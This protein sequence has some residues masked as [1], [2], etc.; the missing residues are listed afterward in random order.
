MYSGHRQFCVGTLNFMLVFVFEI[1]MFVVICSNYN[2]SLP[3]LPRI[4]KRPW[5][6][7][8]FLD[9]IMHNMV[10]SRGSPAQIIQNSPDVR[11][12]FRLILAEGT[13]NSVKPRERNLR[14]AKHRFESYQRPLGRTVRLFP[15]IV[16]LM[17]Q[18][19]HT[20]RDRRCQNWLE[21]VS[22]SPRHTMQLAMLADAA[23]EGMALTRFCDKEGMDVAALS[24]R[25]ACFLDRIVNLFGPNR[26]CL[27]SPGYTKLMSETLQHPITW[28]IGDR[29]YGTRPPSP[30][31]L[32]FCFGR[33][34]AWCH[35]AKAE[36]AAEFPDWE[37]AQSF[38][39]F[40]IGPHTLVTDDV[41][42]SC[43]Q[44]HLARLAHAFRVD[45]TE[46]EIE[47]QEH[48]HLARQ[49]V[50]QTRCTAQA[51]WVDAINRKDRRQAS[52]RPVDTIK[53]VLGRWLCFIAST[54]GF[55]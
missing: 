51:A 2:K 33:M 1:K 14:A 29:P 12:I 10:G 18:L 47:F 40:D 16:R 39:V 45:P 52:S 46:L 20:R 35:L 53:K 32:A 9:R 3:T 48:Q 54:S 31:D 7:D 5:K 11:S 22:E 28:V 13:V 34:Q 37:L 25:I 23:D 15:Q 8:K 50:D 44:N 42:V 26:A 19:Y 38:R 41:D 30:A 4:L 43:M 6:A 27:T 36:I 55:R 24:G 17:A 21:F 49:A